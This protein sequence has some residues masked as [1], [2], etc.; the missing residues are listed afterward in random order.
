MAVVPFSTKVLS[1]NPKI[2][3]NLS[4]AS[5]N[6]V[7]QGT[8]G[9]AGDADNANGNPQRQQTSLLKDGSDFSVRMNNGKI[10]SNGNPI[11]TVTGFTLAFLIDIETEATATQEILRIGTV[12]SGSP[13][14]QLQNKPTIGGF[15]IKTGIT[16]GVHQ[17]DVGGA[18]VG[19]RLFITITG[20]L[21]TELVEVRIDGRVRQ[22]ATATADILALTDADLEFNRGQS[23]VYFV[24]EFAFFDTVLTESQIVDL[25]RSTRAVDDNATTFYVTTAG[26][27]YGKGT[28]ADPLNLST[29]ANWSIIDDTDNADVIISGGTYTQGGRLKIEVSNTGS[30]R[31]TFRNKPGELV[32]IRSTAADNIIEFESQSQNVD[33][34]G[35]DYGSLSTLGGI[36]VENAN[37]SRTSWYNNYP[38]ENPLQDGTITND[39]FTT[40]NPDVLLASVHVGHAVRVTDNVGTLLFSSTI[41]SIQSSKDCTFAD[42]YG[43]TLPLSSTARMYVDDTLAFRRNQSFL[44]TGVNNRVIGVLIQDIGTA[45]T[46]FEPASQTGFYYNICR[47]SFWV[48]PDRQH[49]HG[50]YIANDG[51]NGQKVFKGNIIYNETISQRAESVSGRVEKVLIE[52]GISWNEN[53]PQNV[54]NHRF[55]PSRSTTGTGSAASDQLTVA[56]ATGLNA[57]DRL[58]IV[59]ANHYDEDFYVSIEAV[60]GSV[61]TLVEPLPQAVTDATVTK[62]VHDTNFSLLAGSDTSNASYDI[63]VKNNRLLGEKNDL[64]IGYTHNNNLNAVVT[65]NFAGYINSQKWETLTVTGNTFYQ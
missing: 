13:H 29:A 47:N 36:I 33:L 43:G 63:E 45:F 22:S 53:D 38:D 14:I 46:S 55:R 25:F 32:R 8:L 48:A 4:E 16:G 17:K 41:L 15:V 9:T 18:A 60:A 50:F 30:N 11:T 20:D 23:L 35:Y 19:Q 26:S 37:A 65:G 64:N 61:I 34:K 6:F 44:D 52:H 39:T 59:G 10:K 51:A 7:N 54:Y 2:Y 56:D 5:G 24:D 58:R 49:G 28:E 42:S 12:T 62:A 31:I 3:L 27:S 1:Y 57:G 21:T 40:T